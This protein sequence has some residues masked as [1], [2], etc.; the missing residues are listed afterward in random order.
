VI[1]IVLVH[2]EV[3]MSATVL[4]VDDDEEV[5]RTFANWLQCEGYEVR[6]AAD[7]EAAL[8]QVTGANAIVVDLRMPILDGLGFLRCVRDG[9][10]HVPVVI[11][12]G[13]Y[14]ID[15]AVTTEFQKL[16]ARVVFKPLWLDELVTL[17]AAL[18][19]PTFA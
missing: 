3:E 5:I 10:E 17:T 16:N 2:E 7:G 12:T 11:V 13:D 18:V 9:D 4:L 8:R 19:R 6:T 1:R 14:L 15:D